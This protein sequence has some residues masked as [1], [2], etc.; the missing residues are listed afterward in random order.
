LG[1]FTGTIGSGG[2]MQHVIGASFG[3]HLE[4]YSDGAHWVVMRSSGDTASITPA[5]LGL[6]KVANARPSDLPISNAVSS[7]MTL[8]ANL[9]GANFR[10]SI[11]APTTHASTSILVGGPNIH[12]LYVRTSDVIG[13]INNY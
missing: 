11:T 9:M 5:T 1:N 7:A 10:G 2:Q 6:G 13:S 4:T 12:D 8:K 3:R